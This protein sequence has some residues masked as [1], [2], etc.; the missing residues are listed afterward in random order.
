MANDEVVIIPRRAKSEPDWRITAPRL[1]LA[2]KYGIGPSPW[3]NPNWSVEFDRYALGRRPQSGLPS[4]VDL[5]VTTLM[6]SRVVSS[7]LRKSRRASGLNWRND[8]RIKAMSEYKQQ[9]VKMM[10]VSGGAAF[11][12]GFY[13]A[14]GA[15][16]MSALWVAV[17]AIL[18][19]LVLRIRQ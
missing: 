9:V 3:K 2:L 16:F 10:D 15:L 1:K 19:F 12:F 13:A 11:K 6:N 5:S 8:G 7:G 4:L 18:Y 14:F 17:W